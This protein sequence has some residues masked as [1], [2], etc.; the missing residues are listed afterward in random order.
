M[1]HSLAVVPKLQKLGLGTI[2]MNSFIS[3][4]ESSG[5]ADRIVLLAHEQM[6]PYYKRLKFEDK[7]LSKATF[8]GGGW[9]DMV[10]VQALDS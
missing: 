3:K 9:H 7:G 8:G 2:L 4:I 10:S 6:I 1:I 5:V